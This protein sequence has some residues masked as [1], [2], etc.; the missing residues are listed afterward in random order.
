[1]GGGHGYKDELEVL[2]SVIIVG[3]F[4]PYEIGCDLVMKVEEKFSFHVMPDLKCWCC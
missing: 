3:V 4:D 1:M 2:A